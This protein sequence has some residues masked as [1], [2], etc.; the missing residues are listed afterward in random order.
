[1]TNTKKRFLNIYIGTYLHVLYSHLSAESKSLGKTIQDEG[2]F[3]GSLLPTS[4][5]VTLFSI[6]IQSND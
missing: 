1:M 3:A 6:Q 2:G 4:G 5:L